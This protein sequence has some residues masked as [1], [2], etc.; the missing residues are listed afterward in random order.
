MVCGQKRKSQE[1]EKA[2]RTAFFIL[3]V[4][5]C[6]PVVKWARANCFALARNLASQ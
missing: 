1:M 3:L 5:V 4:F 6:G 2:V